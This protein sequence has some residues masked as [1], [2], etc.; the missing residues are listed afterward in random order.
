MAVQ[1]QLS[2]V[3]LGVQRQT[4]GFMVDGLSAD[5]YKP[6]KLEQAVHAQKH[7]AQPPTSQH[8]QPRLQ[9]ESGCLK[10]RGGTV[11]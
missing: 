5:D 10:I 8:P 9:C 3:G 7:E 1:V 4:L 11:D 6:G 2:R